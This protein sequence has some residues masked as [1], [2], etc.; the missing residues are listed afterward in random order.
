[1]VVIVASLLFAVLAKSLVYCLPT[2]FWIVYFLEPTG[3]LKYFFLVLL[4][5]WLVSQELKISLCTK[6]LVIH[7][8]LFFMFGVDLFITWLFS[9]V[10]FVAEVLKRF[11]SHRVK[12]MQCFV[13]FFLPCFSFGKKYECLGKIKWKRDWFRPSLEAGK[14][15]CMP[16]VTSVI[17]RLFAL[18]TMAP[19]TLCPWDSSGRST[20]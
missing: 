6:V 8:V 14:G 19:R 15:A 9:V 2:V 3:P 18:W 7:L 12:L 17:S 10:S 16:A 11:F 5:S 13:S 1:M 20:G 4:V